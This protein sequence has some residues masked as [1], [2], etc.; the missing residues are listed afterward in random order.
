MGPGVL[1]SFVVGYFVL[2][3]VIAHFTSA[4]SDNDTFFIA[5]KN[6]KWWLVA[7]GMI[8]TSISGVT[9][10]SV[11]GTV[12][13]D[14]FSY[15]QF[16]LGNVVG[17]IL[18]ATI[19]MPLYYRMNLI[20]IYTYLERRLGHWSYQTGAFIFLVSRTIGSA[21]RLFLVAIVLQKFIFDAWNIPF[22]VT[23]AVSLLLIWT[24]T[25][26]GGLKTIIWT[27][28]IQTFF[29]LISVLLTIILI[30]KNLHL[31]LVG[32]FET[33][34]N[35]AY[36]RIFWWDHFR[37]EKRQFF[38]EFLGGIAVAVAMTGL[39]QDLMQK[40]LSCK[41][42]REAKKNMFSF[43]GVFILVNIFFLSVGALLYIFALRRHIPLP[44]RSDYLF[45]FIAFHYL[46][47]FAAIVFILG[48]TAATFATTD[49]ALTA[50]TT[51]FCLDFL[52]FGRRKDEVDAQKL[53][54]TRY[55][56]HLFFSLIF[57]LVVVGF[58]YLVSA[59]VVNAIFTV[60]S[61]TYGPLLGL[62]IFGIGTNRQVRD[63]WVPWVCALSP[64]LCFLLNKYSQL[65][66]G[67][68]VFG[69]E[70]LIVNGFITFCG[71]WLISQKEHRK[72]KPAG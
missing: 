8:G 44:A 27:D 10:I 36:S 37:Q 14:L 67:G 1:F 43:T 68:Y 9:F 17:Y 4:K 66:F 33:V 57:L 39:D 28:T 21:F 40:N 64:A 53:V 30:G 41:N 23:V 49:S 20:S 5:N 18:I 50:L 63:S 13:Q 22:W 16:V 32:L 46:G 60:A 62:F 58:R 35:S 59:A 25:F 51:S 29:L 69:F 48:L 3:L 34:K 15:F 71:L 45:P 6:S 52:H 24:Y 56:V 12:N 61:F 2:L 19:L 72:M 38:K 26:R 7:F 70:L 54:R 65:L 31:S 55:L 11:P 42:I 47:G